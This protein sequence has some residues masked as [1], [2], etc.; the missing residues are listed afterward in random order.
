M[1]FLEP[2]VAQLVLGALGLEG[3]LGKYPQL[4]QDDCADGEGYNQAATRGEQ[5]WDEVQ[6]TAAQELTD[7]DVQAAA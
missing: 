6:L 4:H 2:I 5:D 7:V 3:I 1:T